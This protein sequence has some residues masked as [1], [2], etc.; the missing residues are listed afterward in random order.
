[1]APAPLADRRPRRTGLTD[2]IRRRTALVRTDIDLAGSSDSSDSS[3]LEDSDE[4]API[5]DLPS[6]DVSA[7]DDEDSIPSTWMESVCPVEASI[8]S[9]GDDAPIPSQ[10][11]PALP[12]QSP[13]SPTPTADI[14]MD[15]P[16]ADAPEPTDYPEEHFSGGQLQSTAFW[17]PGGPRTP[18]LL[19]TYDTH[20]ARA[21]YDVILFRA[22]D[23]AE[24]VP[25]AVDPPVRLPM[26]RRRVG[27]VAEEFEE[28]EPIPAAVRAA[29]LS[30]RARR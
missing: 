22:P 18:V 29:Q 27:P 25:V 23:A 8:R 9:V 4:D 11:S 5:A 13:D 1:M 16:T 26:R 15:S 10:I 19:T 17:M 24:D 3:A 28:P 21:I 2:F 20:I 12:T 7:A 6:S 30:G 14:H